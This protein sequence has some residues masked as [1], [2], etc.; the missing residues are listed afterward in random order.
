MLFNSQML[1]LEIDQYG[2]FL[3]SE[4]S[5][6]QSESSSTAISSVFSPDSMGREVF[7]PGSVL[8]ASVPLREEEAGQSNLHQERHIFLR[9]ANGPAYPGIHPMLSS[10]GSSANLNLYPLFG[11][12]D[13]NMFY[14]NHYYVSSDPSTS[15]WSYIIHASFLLF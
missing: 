15:N 4:S 5:H 9:D 2:S 11:D 13:F 1:D 10:S 7:T 14:G 8:P 6:L 12:H 3:Q